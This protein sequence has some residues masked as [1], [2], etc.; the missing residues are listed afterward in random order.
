MNFH[1]CLHL[2]I[3]NFQIK[4]YAWQQLFNITYV[5][6]NGFFDNV[7]IFILNIFGCFYQFLFNL[8]KIKKERKFA[9]TSRLTLALKSLL[10]FFFRIAFI[11][12]YE[13]LANCQSCGRTS[14]TSLAPTSLIKTNVPTVTASGNSTPTRPWR[15]TSRQGNQMFDSSLLFV[16]LCPTKV[17][18]ERKGDYMLYIFLS[19][20]EL[21][22]NLKKKT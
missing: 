22:L 7:S 8:S 19:I 15:S 12:C 17:F 18:I 20:L 13:H 9:R 14:A 4:P 10:S 3:L 1:I 5:H 16:S 6:H 21:I 2:L 11:F